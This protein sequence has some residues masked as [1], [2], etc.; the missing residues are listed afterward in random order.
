MNP[1]MKKLP[2]TV[3]S[4]T[5]V[6]LLAISPDRAD[7]QSLERILDKTRWTIHGASTYREATRLIR[8][9]GPSLILCERDLPDGSWKDVFR[10]AGVLRNPPPVV[11]ASRQADERL[12]AEVLNLGGFDV[13][14]KPFENME[15]RRV[16]NM[17]FRHGTHP[18][19]VQP[20]VA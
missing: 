18:Y 19:A 16:M 17:A 3:P 15:V 4:N 6:T 5:K 7:C 20:A 13:L 10:E 9:S 2:A 8:E 14:L 12:W 1:T 11:V